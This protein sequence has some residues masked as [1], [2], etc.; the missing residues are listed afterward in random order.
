MSA[1]SSFTHT[2][3]TLG[4]IPRN[5]FGSCS[6]DYAQQTDSSDSAQDFSLSPCSTISATMSTMSPLEAGQE[7]LV[8]QQML[9]LT[10]GSDLNRSSDSF[11]FLP[12]TARNKGA[13]VFHGVG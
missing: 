9:S 4:A 3:K 5:I 11:S 10:I 7:S 6:Q 8:T 12:G 13:I 1:I 2:E